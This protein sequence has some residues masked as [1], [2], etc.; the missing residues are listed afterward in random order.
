VDDAATSLLMEQFYENLWHKGLGKLESLRQAQ[1]AVLNHPEW[2]DKRREELKIQ[3]AARGL[4]LTSRPLPERSKTHGRSHPA[5]WAAFVLSGDW[6]Q[7]LG[8][9]SLTRQAFLNKLHLSQS[10]HQ[11]QPGSVPSAVVSP[12]LGQRGGKSLTL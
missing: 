7:A 4:A 2:I 3:L 12:A 11:H 9:S 5:H 10:Q 6:R 8:C 1:L